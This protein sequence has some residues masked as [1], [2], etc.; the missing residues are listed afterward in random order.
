MKGE[1][2]PVMV[3]TAL[4]RSSKTAL[5][6]PKVSRTRHIALYS[7]ARFILIKSHNRTLLIKFINSLKC[8]YDVRRLNVILN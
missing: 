4:R 2:I 6:A 7:V 8:N 1:N 3:Y 5:Y